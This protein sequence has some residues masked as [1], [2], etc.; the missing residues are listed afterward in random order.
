[1]SVQAPD[2]ETSMT[3]AEHAPE[4]SALSFWSRLCRICLGMTLLGGS[5]GFSYPFAA[6]VLAGGPGWTDLSL[7]VL[8]CAVPLTAAGAAL[9]AS[10]LDLKTP[11]FG[12]D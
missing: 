9:A 8:L 12:I 6:D 3:I 10:C 7:I 2:F 1:M 5:A 11:A 4:P